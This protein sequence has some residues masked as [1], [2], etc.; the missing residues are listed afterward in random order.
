MA[1]VTPS[2][3]SRDTRFRVNESLGGDHLPKEIFLD[4]P[5]QRILPIIL[6]R[7]Q[8]AKAD[9]NTFETKMADI[10]NSTLS[11]SFTPKS[12]DMD[13]YQQH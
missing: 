3:K 4:R 8:F 11:D 13:K 6:S 1:F 7:Y 5:L 10:F 2:L 12:S 9:I